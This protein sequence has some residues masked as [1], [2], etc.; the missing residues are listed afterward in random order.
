MHLHL[1]RAEDRSKGLGTELVARSVREYLELFELERLYCEPH[2][3]D[4]APNRT[5]QAAGFAYVS[6]Q[7]TTPTPLNVEQVTNLW[8][9][10]PSS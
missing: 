10:Q 2:A 7:R 9:F 1:V 3:F 5:L 8:V 6:T 4:V